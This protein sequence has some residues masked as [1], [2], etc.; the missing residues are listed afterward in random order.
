MNGDDLVTL[1]IFDKESEAAV[2]WS[3]LEAHGISC[4]LGQRTT[5]LPKIAS[6]I[7]L[8]VSVRDYDAAKSIMED[9]TPLPAMA[10][11][12]IDKDRAAVIALICT[13]IMLAWAVFNGRS[14]GL[15]FDHAGAMQFYWFVAVLWLVCVA[16]AI[17]VQGRWWL[18][19][20]AP[21]PLYQLFELI[22]SL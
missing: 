3:K 22:R 1:Q 20:W 9:S 8:L 5:Y 4:H 10:P 13:A 6:G 19:M 18:L 17:R 21:I 15:G 16:E 11:A 7:P 12:P 14:A 2:V